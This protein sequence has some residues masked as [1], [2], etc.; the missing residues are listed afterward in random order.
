MTI[1]D[2]N[3]RKNNLKAEYQQKENSLT[4]EFID[5]NNPYKIGDIVTDHIGSIK[6]ESMSYYISY[7][8]PEATYTGLELKKDKTPTKKLSKRT[9]YQNNII[10]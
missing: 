10:K 9:V 1:E 8:K 5:S 6:I 7:S 2:Y 4:K 3:I